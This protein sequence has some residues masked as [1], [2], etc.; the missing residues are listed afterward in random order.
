MIIYKTDYFEVSH[1]SI[2][3]QTKLYQEN[4]SIYHQNYVKYEI[5]NDQRRQKDLEYY[6]NNDGQKIYEPEY[7]LEIFSLDIKR[8]H[9]CNLNIDSFERKKESLTNQYQNNQEMMSQVD[10]TDQQQCQ[11]YFNLQEIQ[12]NAIQKQQQTHNLKSYDN[13]NYENQQFN[14][15][16]NSIS[17]KNEII[18]IQQN[19][20][21]QYFKS[22][23]NDISTSIINN[24][25]Q[26]QNKNFSETLCTE[27]KKQN[28]QNI[29]KNIV[30][31]F[32]KYFKQIKDNKFAKENESIAWLER[33]KVVN[34]QEVQQKIQFL[35][36]C[37]R[38]PSEF[39]ELTIY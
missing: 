15:S 18:Q 38:D 19:T 30:Q 10:L 5:K 3:P 17:N 12:G 20:F 29:L 22:E 33:S 16:Y 39:E 11:P 1:N 8:D 31:A 24:D 26:S 14:Q 32:L 4:Q 25:T 34:K 27:S 21:D 37:I 35:Q 13:N 23:N 9:S 36:N 6:Y 7:F 28:T 2:Q